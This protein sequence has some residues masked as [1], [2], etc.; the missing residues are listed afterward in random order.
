MSAEGGL[1]AHI[2]CV[3][4]WQ[5]NLQG[6]YLGAL[7]ATLEVGEQ[8]LV[9]VS[10]INCADVQETDLQSCRA[11]GSS[12]RR[13]EPDVLSEGFEGMIDTRC[14]LQQDTPAY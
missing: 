3:T 4:G 7:G 2:S 10:G 6:G 1:N 11:K 5:N 12:V 14:N 13:E 9:R 8:F